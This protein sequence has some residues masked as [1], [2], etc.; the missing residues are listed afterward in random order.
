MSMTP[1]GMAAKIQAALKSNLLTQTVGQMTQ[2]DIDAAQ[3]KFL[4][5]FCTGILAE[6]TANSELFPLSTDSGDAGAG[7]ITGKVI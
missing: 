4:T 6:V 1:S 5:A 3:L 7:I 2:G